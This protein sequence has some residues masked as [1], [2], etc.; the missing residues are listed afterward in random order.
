MLTEDIAWAAL[1]AVP[2]HLSVLDE[3]GTTVFVNAAWRRFAR[4]NGWAE[5]NPGLG[6]N[7][8]AV[9]EAAAADGI[10]EAGRVAA[11]LRELLS[12][13]VA[14]AC[15]EDMPHESGSHGELYPCHSPVEQRWFRVSIHRLDVPGPLRVLV[16][17]D[18]VTAQQLAAVAEAQA[19]ASA[20]LAERQYR[21]IFVAGGDPVFITDDTGI[22]LDANPSACLACAMPLPILHGRR[23]DDLLDP[24]ESTVFDAR[25]V[26]AES[27][28]DST[29]GWR[30]E[31]RLRSST[32]DVVP[33][34]A[35]VTTVASGDGRL[36][37]WVMRDMSTQHK[38]AQMQRDFVGLVS[39]ELKGPLTG[40][41]GFAQLLARR[42][43]YNPKWVEAILEQSRNLDRLIDDL[44]DATR[45]ETGQLRVTRERVDL[46]SLVHGV[47]EQVSMSADQH[48]LAVFLPDDPVIGSFDPARINQVMLNLLTNAMKYSPDGGRIDVRLEMRDGI[49]SIGVSDQGVGIAPDLL[50]QLF[51]RYYRVPGQ[52]RD[53][54]AG[55]GIGLYLSQAIAEAHGGTIAVSSELGSGSTFTVQMPIDDSLR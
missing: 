21:Q 2:D 12:N 5:P 3:M 30:G 51:D 37:I 7:Y 29:D 47:V 31:L 16:R 4:D 54:V 44:L 26:L 42:E 53:R 43:R 35:V 48:E 38:V 15:S 49:V 39:H 19:R 20:A 36:V 17:H 28:I 14:T 23:L 13:P 50:P 25:Q 55:L 10:A 41:K 27:A 34:E 33:I 45:A 8:L 18:N 24:S 11:E 6:W 22:I 46:S 32:G 52:V 1:D 9:C 40:L